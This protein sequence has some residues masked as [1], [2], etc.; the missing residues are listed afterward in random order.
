MRAKLNASHNSLCLMATH[1][2]L[3]PYS[4]NNQIISWHVSCMFVTP[5][6]STETW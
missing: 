2:S 3:E 4:V 5:T 1:I 6:A